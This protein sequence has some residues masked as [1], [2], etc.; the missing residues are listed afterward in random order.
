MNFKQPGI[1]RLG[2]SLLAFAFL[3]VHNQE[4]RAQ[5]EWAYSQ[6][7]FNLFDINSAYAGSHNDLSFALRYRRQWVGFDGAPETQSFSVHSPVFNPSWASGIKIQHET[8]GARKI[9]R[10]KISVAHRWV[11]GNGRLSAALSAGVLRQEM[12][13]DNLNIRDENDPLLSHANWRGTTPLAD[14]AIIFTSDKIYLGVETQGANRSNFHWNE[15]S[16]ARLYYHLYLTGGWMKKVGKKNIL[17]F[18]GLVKFSEGSI[19]QAEA[20]ISYLFRDAL[21]IGTGY[22]PG[23]GLVAFAQLAISPRWRLGYAFDYA[24]GP[25]SRYQQ[26]SHEIFLG[27]NVGRNRYRSIR[28]F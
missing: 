27:F 12:N 26:G 11:A 15:M 10:A 5:Q 20:D 21:W 16:G 1:C 4:C 19:Y 6:Y 22:R 2:I 14:A 18:S 8:I 7:Q 23:Y 3:I 9:A 17:Q 25:L 28:Y 24:T 13:T